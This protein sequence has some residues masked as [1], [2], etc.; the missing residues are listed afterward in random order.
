MAA[1]PISARL[2]CGSSAMRWKGA[3]N[4][5]VT[6][7]AAAIL[8]V[9]AKCLLISARSAPAENTL[10]A[11]RTCRTLQSVRRSSPSRM[12]LKALNMPASK[13]LTGGR[14]SVMVAT[15]SAT[16]RLMGSAMPCALWANL[17]FDW[18]VASNSSDVLCGYLARYALERCPSCV[19]LGTRQTAADDEPLDIVGALIDFGAAHP[20]ID[21]LDGKVLHVT[22]PAQSLD[23][24]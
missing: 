1:P 4:G 2:T 23:R 13:A 7:A 11:L 20:T 3:W 5:R 8:S 22:G 17:R 16:L 18:W 14:L 15:P 6:S 24:V 12:A 9:L 19:A 10:S 21:A